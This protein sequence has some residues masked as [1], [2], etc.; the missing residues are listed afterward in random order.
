M[1]EVT[2]QLKAAVKKGILKRQDTV[3]PRMRSVGRTSYGESREAPKPH[4]QRTG[5]HPNDERVRL[6][7]GVQK[8]SSKFQG[9]ATKGQAA[10]IKSLV[11]GAG[12]KPPSSS[13][14]KKKTDAQGVNK[15]KYK[16]EMRKRGRR[17]S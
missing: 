9:K 14:K 11:K 10:R 13:A 3:L 6:K 8:D 1:S 12:T 17:R 2:K 4:T 7:K 5:P 15:K 16:K